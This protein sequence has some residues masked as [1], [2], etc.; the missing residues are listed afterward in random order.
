MCSAGQVASNA[1]GKLCRAT[2]HMNVEQFKS[3]LET[4]GRAWEARDP[5]AAADLFSEDATYQERPFSEPMRGR[6]S[7]F[8]YWSHVA[9]T[10]ERVQFAY[11]IVTVT[12]ESG[13][14]HWW[15]SMTHVRSRE[16]VRLDGIFI[17]SLDNQNRCKKLQ[18]WWQK[19]EVKSD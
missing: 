11:E 6:S 14:A 18:E 9:R 4:Y 13:I 19:E 2:V 17:I 3:W 16:G 7:I 1:T 5:Q 8:E 10:W 15:A 12:E